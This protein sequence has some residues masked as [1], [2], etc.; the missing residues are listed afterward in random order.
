MTASAASRPILQ[1]SGVETDDAPDRKEDVMEKFITN[2]MEN[3]VGF[4]IAG[5]AIHF[6]FG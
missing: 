1:E 4:F 5:L 6:L 3:A 2:V